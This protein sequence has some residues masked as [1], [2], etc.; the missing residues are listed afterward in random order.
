[1]HV[2]NVGLN[3]DASLLT[4]LCFKI[5]T[6]IFFAYYFK[7]LGYIGDGSNLY[8][9]S[10]EVLFLYSSVCLDAVSIDY[11]RDFGVKNM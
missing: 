11:Y 9:T 5:Q 10:H 7:L 3:V 2:F 4:Q 6:L 1:M 8:R